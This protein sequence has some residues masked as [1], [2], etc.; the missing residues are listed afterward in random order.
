MSFESK[1]AL[2]PG[3][4]EAG[5]EVSALCGPRWQH[6]EAHVACPMFQRHQWRLSC[7]PTALT[8]VHQLF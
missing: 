6:T 8:G 3:K 1:N 2:G 4:Q 7:R 5:S